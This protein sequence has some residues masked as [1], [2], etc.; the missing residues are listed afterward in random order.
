MR[1]PTA[2]AAALLLVA[3]P[4]KARA[5]GPEV[6]LLE[7]AGALGAL[8]DAAA[9]EDRPLVLHFWALW[10]GACREEMP[11]LARTFAEA[12]QRGARV[13]LVSLDP[14]G[15]RFSVLRGFL[16]QAG[17]P[18]ERFV[19]DAPDPGPVLERVG[20]DWDGALPATFVFRGGRRTL[21][22]VGKVGRGAKLLDAL[23]PVG[24]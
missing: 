2:L 14:P 20:A 7:G 23:G 22:V 6:A 3:V 16:D 18:G 11:S 17:V 24:R 19:L 5:P 15:K 21:D 10:C 12:R 4:A 9:R 1:R 8:L 13:V